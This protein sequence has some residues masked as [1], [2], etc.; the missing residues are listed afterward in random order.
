MEKRIGARVR[1]FRMRKGVSQSA[2]GEHVGLTFQQIQKYEKG[3]NRISVSRLIE[4]SHVLAFDINEFLDGIEEMPKNDD[5]TLNELYALM[6][7]SVEM[8]VLRNLAA[9][10]DAEVRRK[11]AELIATIRNAE[12]PEPVQSRA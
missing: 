11:L 6:S 7:S 10:E 9:I 2:L 1:F 5:A 12:V 3:S 4:F 8:S